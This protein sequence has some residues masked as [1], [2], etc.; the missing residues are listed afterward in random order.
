M[1]TKQIQITVT[2]FENGHILLGKNYFGEYVVKVS[3][4]YIIEYTA[5][6]MKEIYNY[7]D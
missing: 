6:E 4:G 5:A 7:K 3:G 1:K 2:E